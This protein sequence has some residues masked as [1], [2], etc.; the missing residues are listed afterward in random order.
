[1]TQQLPAHHFAFE[2]LILSSQSITTESYEASTMQ[3]SNQVTKGPRRA[4]HRSLWYA[5]GLT[6]EE[7]KGPLV[8]IANSGTDLVPGHINLNRIAEAVKAGIWMA[9]G[10]PLEFSTIA[11]C[12]GISMGHP[13]MYYALPSRELIADSVETMIKA[14]SL[15]GLVMIANCDKIVPGMLMAAAR[16]NVPAI[17]VSGGPMLAG[18]H[19]GKSI[20]H[21]Q[22]HESVGL[23]ER[24]QITSEY[25]EQLEF[26]ACPGW[27]SCAGLFTANTMNCL[28]E[29]LGIAL[30]GNG[31]APAVSSERIRIAKQAGRQIIHLV[32]RQIK[33]RDILTDTAFAN[34]IAVDMA[35]GG[36]T[37]T[38]LHLIAIAREAG[39]HLELK[40]FDEI[41]KKTPNIVKLSPATTSHMED[42]HNAGGIPAVIRKLISFGAFNPEPGTVLDSNIGQVA[43]LEDD[44]VQ[45]VILDPNSPYS[46]EGGLA[47]LYGNV[48]PIGAVVK[49]SAV[50]AEML[51]HEGPARVFDREE[52]AVN[53]IIEGDIEPGFVIVIR[54]EGPKGS[55]G[56]REMLVPTSTLMGMGLG[57]SVALITDGRFSG[58]SRGPVIGHI[59]PE[60]MSGGPLALLEDGDVIDIDIPGGR[61]DARLSPADFEKRRAVWIPP[62]R[63]KLSGYLARYVSMVTEASEGAVLS[64]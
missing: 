43:A 59:S 35:I 30:P 15:D 55:P 37:N 29:T 42:L 40:T 3:L 27:G 19:Q 50:S 60:A 20:D 24:E 41:S 2:G 56:M 53:A 9:G 26:A 25:M 11:I 33:P 38:I 61:L 64:G 57:E 28:A 6:S 7:L 31:T 45:G 62:T 48:A 34:A 54:Y 49:K 36:S 32:E 44:R 16:I 21:T 12:D 10:T 63:E 51:I 18:Q 39:I 46:S 58:V 17:L 47:V 1:M 8:G 52:D 22:V 5:C 14:H 13:G 4:P 23:L